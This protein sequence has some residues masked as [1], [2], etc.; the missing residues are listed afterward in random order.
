MNQQ[1]PRPPVPPK[2]KTQEEFDEL[3]AL[4]VTVTRGWMEA[5]A[6]REQRRARMQ[7]QGGER[8]VA[9]ASAADGR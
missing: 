7:E 3:Y 9:Q 1:P 4:A 5:R 2:P 8:Y 6:E